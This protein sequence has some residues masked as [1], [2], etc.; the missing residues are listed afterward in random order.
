M[1]AILCLLCWHYAQCFCH[2]LPNNG[3]T[4]YVTT[5]L[6]F[7]F[8]AYVLLIVAAMASAFRYYQVIETTTRRAIPVN[9]TACLLSYSQIMQVTFCVLSLYTTVYHFY[10]DNKE[11]YC[12]MDS[13]VP[14]FNLDCSFHSYKIL[15]FAQSYFVIVPTNVLLISGKTV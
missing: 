1:L 4:S 12:G 6:S 5:R 9:A 8:P 13:S 3:I 15:Y 2:L 11:F 10:A 7:I 14:P